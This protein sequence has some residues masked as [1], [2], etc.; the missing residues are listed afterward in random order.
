MTTITLQGTRVDFVDGETSAVS[1]DTAVLTMPSKN[2]TFSYS[3][4]YVDEGVP[5]VEVDD[6]LIQAVIAGYP[7]SDLEAYAEVEAFVVKVTWSEGTTTVF[8]LNWETSDVNDSDLYFVLDGPALPEVTT[9]AGWEAFDATITAVGAATGQFAAG[10]DIRWTEFDDYEITEEDELYG[11]NRRDTLSGGI[12]DDYFV[13]SKGNDTYNGGKGYDQ[14]TFN[15]DPGGV[16]ANLLKGTATDGWGNTDTLNSIEMLRGSA[17]DDK[18]IGNN[19]GNILRGLA[20]DD[21]LNGGKGRD[22]VRYDRDDRYGGDSG[23]TVNLQK[24]FATDGFGDRDTVRNVENVR[25]SDYN[26]RI[27]GDG[28]ANEL[29]GEGGSDK[30]Y[31][32]NGRDKLFGGAG[33]DLLNGGNGNDD[34]YGN[35]GADKFV[36]KGNFGH[37]TIHDFQTGGTK[38]RIDLSAIDEI[39][40]F[41]DLKNN[42]LTKVDGNAVITDDDGNTITLDGVVK[43]DL[44]ANDFIF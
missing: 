7:L 32:M 43:A 31:G 35:G 34:L 18:L 30:L 10:Q 13:S 24:E 17:Y 12:G 37:D 20:G 8:G 22:E 2:A 4:D 29:E 23:V 25:G 14:V 41:R 3:I 5:Y 44:S 36:F 39:R 42:H 33:R 16:V 38:E 1:T 9:A 26:D 27:I 40:S 28:K 11:T 21:L 6:N 15:N 19:G